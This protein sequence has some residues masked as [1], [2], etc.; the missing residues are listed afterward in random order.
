MVPAG[1]ALAVGLVLFLVPGFVFLAF[2]R[3]ED[4]DELGFDEAVF[5][6]VAVSVAASSWVALVLA[7]AGRFSLVRG[8]AA[9]ALLTALAAF[10]AA[11][12]GH[13]PGRP[14]PRWPGLA[15]LGAALAVLGLA[16]GLQTR[17]SEYVMGGRD[18]DRKSVV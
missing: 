6:A 2:L 11:R 3:G 12:F 18:P 17:P 10:A 15:P 14:W 13:R 7:E 1:T 9:V 4:R 5:A 16:L 8:A